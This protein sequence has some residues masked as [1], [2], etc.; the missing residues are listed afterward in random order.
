MKKT[1]GIWLCVVALSVATGGSQV[2][3]QSNSGLTNSDAIAAVATSDGYAV[4]A[5]VGL[6]PSCQ[7]A[8]LTPLR[9]PHHYLLRLRRK[10]GTE[11]KICSD[12]YVRAFVGITDV[13]A[14]TT[15]YVVTASG[16]QEV[17]VVPSGGWQ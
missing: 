7:Q 2:R 8:A 12:L 11:G 5:R 17:P 15:V 10:P 16:T 6:S 4:I 1:L 3:A 14:A 13:G 9:A